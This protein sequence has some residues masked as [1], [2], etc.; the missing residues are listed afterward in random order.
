MDSNKPNNTGNNEDMSFLEESSSGIQFKDILFLIIR[1]LHWFILCALI[2]AGIAYYKVKGEERV[3]ASSATIMLKTG[4]NGGTESLRSSAVMNEF[5][6]GIAI[7]SIFNEMMIIRSQ[8]LMENVV[9]RL[10]LNTMYSYT[11]RLAKRNKA[12]YKESPIEVKFPE[13]NEQM[14]ASFVVTPT[15]TATVVLS[16]FQGREDLPPMTVNVDSVVNTPVGKVIVS[17]TW[18]YNESFND[19]SINVQHLP[20]ATVATWYRYAVNVSPDDEKKNTIL[21]L[22]ITDSSPTRAADVLNTLIDVYNDDSMEDQKRILQYSTQYINDRISYL[23]RDIESISKQVVNF[24]KQYNIIDVQ[25]FGQSYVASSVE[26][27]QELKD[28]ETQRDLVNYLIEFVE[29]NTEQD[30][31]PSNMGLKGK[32]VALIDKYNELVLQVNEYKHAGTINNPNAQAKLIELKTLES[33]VK[34]SL[35]S[36]RKELVARIRAVS[37]GRNSANI[38]VQSVPEEQLRVNAIE[39]KKQIKEGLLMTML[40]KREELLLNEPKIEPSCKVIDQAWANYTPI[41]PKPRKAVTRGLLIGLLVPVVVI[42]LRKLLDTRVHFRGDVER[43]TKAPFLGEI[44][45]KKDA[46]DHAIVVRENGRDSVSEAFR[47]VRSNLEYMKN[48]DHEGGQVVMFTSFIVASGKTFV[49]TN[50][51]T[52]FALANKKVVLVDLDIRKAT[53]NKVFGIHSRMGVSNYLSGTTDSMDDLINT[54]LVVPNMDVIFSGPVP[55]NPAELLMSNR[56]DEMIDYLRK[57][58]DYVFLD[59]VPLGIVADAEIVKRLADSTVFVVRANKTDKRMINELDRIY[60][61]GRY[62]NLAILLNSVKYKKRR[63]YGYGYGYGYG[64]KN[65]H[66]YYGQSDYYGDDENDEDDSK[67]KKHHRHHSSKK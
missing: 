48:R 61:S 25:S 53:F 36:Y 65:G 12:L 55:P 42:I 59:N 13:A 56:L 67:K 52:S 51:A 11:T 27:S 7:S 45:L 50:L 66:G 35:N 24:Q 47:L 3:Y 28:L 15:D 63:G 54:D 41:A 21:R 39:S 1:N 44:P 23:D 38:K 6:G 16:Q 46:K 64:A 18:F 34:E 19:V 22:S 30:L 20:V 40:T 8:T 57:H 4:N 43:I 37:K 60:K 5:A 10:D 9:R 49:S 2:G 26:Y 29:G 14:S 58:Y 17:Y 33:S 31:I 62:P 32:S